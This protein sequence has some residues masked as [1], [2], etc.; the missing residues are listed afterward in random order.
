MRIRELRLQSDHRAYIQS[1][2]FRLILKTRSAFFSRLLIHRAPN[3]RRGSNRTPRIGLVLEADTSEGSHAHAVAV[4]NHLDSG[5]EVGTSI[6]SG[7]AKQRQKVSHD[8]AGCTCAPDWLDLRDHL[9]GVVTW[10]R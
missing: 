9:R 7:K 2:G 4:D 8:P 1:C 5:L 3:Q 6:R 10:Q